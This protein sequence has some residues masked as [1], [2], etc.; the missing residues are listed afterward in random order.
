MGWDISFFRRTNEALPCDM[1]AW[2]PLGDFNSLV[3]QLKP[4]LGEPVREG[5]GHWVVFR[6]KCELRISVHDEDPIASVSLSVI[7]RGNPFPSIRTIAAALRCEAL[8]MVSLEPIDLNS[9]HSKGWILQ[10]QAEGLF[11]LLR[12]K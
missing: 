9:N 12:T 2:L 10:K 6:D 7:G 11:A 1:D 3:E 4:W 5:A 8:D